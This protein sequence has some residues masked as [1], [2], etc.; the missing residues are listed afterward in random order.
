MLHR[1]EECFSGDSYIYTTTGL[2]QVRQLNSCDVIINRDNSQVR[3]KCLVSIVFDKV[4][5]VVVF[6]NG[7]ITTPFH[8]IKKNNTDWSY[9]STHNKTTRQYV[10]ELYNIVLE[11]TG[12]ITVVL[13]NNNFIDVLTFNNRIVNNSITYHELFSNQI[14][15]KLEKCIGWDN[16]EVRLHTD[17]F[18]TCWQ[19]GVIV[20]LVNNLVI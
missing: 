2:K 17:N 20:D 12:Y 1:Y 18:I 11:D 16:G 5:D 4:I 8:P 6:N 13:N 10:Y 9:S 19:T 7:C 3:V 15:E 14:R